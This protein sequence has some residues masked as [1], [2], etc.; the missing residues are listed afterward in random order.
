[1]IGFNLSSGVDPQ[2]LGE[3]VVFTYLSFADVVSD[4]IFIGT[5]IT[6]AQRNRLLRIV[7]HFQFGQTGAA[8]TRGFALSLRGPSGG[9][10]SKVMIANKTGVG[11]F[12]TADGDNFIMDVRD[13]ATPFVIAPGWFLQ[14]DR[15]AAD[16]GSFMHGRIVYYNVSLPPVRS[17]GGPRQGVPYR[18]NELHMLGRQP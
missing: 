1:V 3:P 4:T 9:A 2:L 13:G 7:V 8:N 18:P 12:D 5:F 15:S 6:E 10:E 17:L 16:A 14:L 11:T